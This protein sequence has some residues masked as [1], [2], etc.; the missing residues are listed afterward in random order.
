MQV[1]ELQRLAERLN[2]ARQLAAT[3]QAQA[4]AILEG[5]ITLYADR[6]WA[7]SITTQARR[8]LA[9]VPQVRAEK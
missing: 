1:A 7:K 5:I 9:D 6:P 3:D 2:A 4:R 8:A